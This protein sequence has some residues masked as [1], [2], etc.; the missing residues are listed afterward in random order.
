MKNQ[1]IVEW[2][3]HAS[4][5][6]V[7]FFGEDN[8]N[9]FLVT[10]GNNN[11]EIKLWNPT[12]QECLQTLSLEYEGK[13]MQNTIRFN[14]SNRFMVVASASHSVVLIF[15]MDFE[16]HLFNSI[17]EYK[18][19]SQIF[20][21]S[22][23][24]EKKVKVGP[25][26]SHSDETIDL[27]FYCV[28]SKGMV[29][30]HVNSRDFLLQQEA[31]HYLSSDAEPKSTP[32]KKRSNAAL[33]SHKTEAP[34]H[35]TTH[36]ATNHQEEQTK[37]EE[38]HKGHHVT[39]LPYHHIHHQPPPPELQSTEN[40]KEEVEPGTIYSL[41]EAKP[42]NKTT[43]E[44]PQETKEAEVTADIPQAAPQL[45]NKKKN[46][47]EK[48]EVIDM[49]K[50]S[51]EEK[52]G[53]ELLAPTAFSIEDA[54]KKKDKKTPRQ[55]AEPSST[56]NTQPTGQTPGKKKKNKNGNSNITEV[57]PIT[58][59]QPQAV[60]TSPKQSKPQP[61]VPVAVEAY[62]PLL[63]NEFRKLELNL[64]MRNESLLK[65]QMENLCMFHLILI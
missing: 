48:E 36:Q 32:S 62:V 52:K 16:N 63:A 64:A 11:S 55:P 24:N 45:S 31:T 37:H 56:A 15:H 35:T 13:G 60:T 27:Q 17:S 23:L 61:D 49:E 53:P 20:S 54:G 1:K 33:H 42:E 47:K 59:Q 21:I 39:K 65:D 2:V 4:V 28:Q 9:T 29:C 44:E 6:S 57:V 43:D 8:H 38:T 26:L 46:K 58:L 18:S 34:T 25:P 3:P 40:S 10:G 50:V 30:F 7:H 19:S 12:N 51:F 41:L 22:V 14:T 5:T